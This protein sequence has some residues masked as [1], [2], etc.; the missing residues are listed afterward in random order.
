MARILSVVLS[1]VLLAAV[2]GFAGANAAD[3]LVRAEPLAR[4]IDA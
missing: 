2:L 3:P 4:V 1:L